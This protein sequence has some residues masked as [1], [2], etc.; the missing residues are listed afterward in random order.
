[1]KDENQDVRS[2]A[3]RSLKKFGPEARAGVPSLVNLLREQNPLTR[4]TAARALGE[5]GPGAK[6]AAP[7]LIKSLNDREGYVREAVARALL[8]VAPESEAAVPPSLL[9]KLKAEIEAE[10]NARPLAALYPAGSGEVVRPR[11]AWS[12]S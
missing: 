7:A 9:Q 6:D 11:E 5:I 12:A 2:G 4:S 10:K 1:M 3:A 8:K